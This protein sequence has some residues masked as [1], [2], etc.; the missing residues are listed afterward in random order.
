MSATVDTS[1]ISGAGAYVMIAAGYSM[2][3]VYMSAMLEP[4]D[5]QLLDSVL[6]NALYTLLHLP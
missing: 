5:E 3:V 6:T 4:L 2:I 1:R